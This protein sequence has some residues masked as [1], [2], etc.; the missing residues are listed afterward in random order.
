MSYGL[1]RSTGLSRSTGNLPFVSWQSSINRPPFTFMP[2]RYH[3]DL[4]AR[5]GREGPIEPVDLSRMEIGEG[6]WRAETRSGPSAIRGQSH[7][8]MLPPHSSLAWYGR[9]LGWV[10]AEIRDLSAFG[11]PAKPENVKPRGD[12]C[13]LIDALQGELVGVALHTINKPLYG[14]VLSLGLIDSRFATPGTQVTIAWGEHPGPGTAP[15]D[16]R[17]FP[18]IR[19][20]VQPAPFEHHARTS[21]RLSA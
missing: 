12:A 21:Y 20:T 17:H 6:Q 2:F 3:P 13:K 11:S 15:E 19:A 18:R 5:E 9:T 8:L 10:S 7:R 1:R 16:H 14:T 4:S